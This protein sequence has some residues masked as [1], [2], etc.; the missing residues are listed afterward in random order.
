MNGVDAMDAAYPEREETLWSLARA[1][2]IWALHFMLCYVTPA[3]YCAKLGASHGSLAPARFAIAG[4]TVPA[5]AALGLI[6]VRAFR[7]ARTARSRQGHEAART[8]AAFMAH[9]DLLLSL[10][11]LTAVVMSSLPALFFGNCE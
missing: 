7:R 9:V 2:L 8:R 10:L 4:F 6:A 1:P 11:S 5:V 3:V